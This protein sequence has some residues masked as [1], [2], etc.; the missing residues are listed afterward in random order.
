MTLQKNFN[1]KAL[2]PVGTNERAPRALRCTH[3]VQKKLSNKGLT[4]LL[5]L[6]NAQMNH[7]FDHRANQ[8]QR[9]STVFAENANVSFKSQQGLHSGTKDLKPG[10]CTRKHTGHRLRALKSGRMHRLAS[11]CRYPELAKD[12]QKQLSEDSCAFSANLKRR[13][14]RFSNSR[15]VGCKPI[16]WMSWQK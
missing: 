8:Y 6:S 12:T 5:T 3:K 13:P 1:A 14:M 7:A 4:L 16:R 15:T 10:I 2:P 11:P 9:S